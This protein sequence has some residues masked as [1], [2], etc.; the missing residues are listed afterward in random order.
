MH[1]TLLTKFISSD[2]ES[3]LCLLSMFYIVMFNDVFYEINGKYYDKF[4]AALSMELIEAFCS[5]HPK[6]CITLHVKC[7]CLWITRL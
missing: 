4:N 2:I 6:H 3:G 1:S 5:L 7:P